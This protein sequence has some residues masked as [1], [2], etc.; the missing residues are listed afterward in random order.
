M[1]IKIL[2]AI[3]GIV[4]AAFGLKS[5]KSKIADKKLND[6]SEE[7]KELKQKQEKLDKQ[8]KE[9]LKQLDLVDAEK[10]TQADILKKLNKEDD[11]E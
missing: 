6:L 10:L 9:V 1:I 7:D 2:L 5:I 3:V 8:N 4:G 11:S